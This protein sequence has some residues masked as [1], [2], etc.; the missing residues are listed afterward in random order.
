MWQID[1]QTPY[2][3][4]GTWARDPEGREIWQVVV[5][6]TYGFDPAGTI[7]IAADQPPVNLACVYRGDAESSSLLYESDF[8]PGKQGSDILLNADA[9]APAGGQVPQLLAGFAVA[10]LIKWVQVTG[11]RHWRAGWIRVVA[12][13]PEPFQRM[14]LIWENAYGGQAGINQAT[15]LPIAYA[16]NPVGKGFVT[17]AAQAVGRPLPNIEYPKRSVASC[18]D[19]VLPAGFGAIPSHWMPRKGY[20]GTYDEEWQRTR[21]PL[22]PRDSSS[23]YHRCAPEDQQL[24]GFLQG[25]E[26]VRLVNLTP[27]GKVAFTLPRLGFRFVTRFHGLPDQHHAPRITLL[28]IEP[29][30]SR[31]SLVFQSDLPCQGDEDRLAETLIQEAEATRD[32]PSACG[33]SAC[34]APWE[35]MPSPA[36]WHGVSATASST[37][38]RAGWTNTAS[39]WSWPQYR[40]WIRYCPPTSVYC[41]W[42]CPVPW[43]PW[44]A[45]IGRRCEAPVTA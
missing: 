43:R 20:G 9:W 11:H 40:G 12:S 8:A 13:P 22:P 10:D 6:A 37:N 32:R 28:I 41:S 4:Q 26:P 17:A 1:N 39:P 23:R 15:G 7:R 36:C 35:R 3:A 27:E 34:T 18:T 14:P 16:P 33:A 25:G 31:F 29:N 5:K 38:T 21:F 44:S 30:A 45:W 42:A 19:L 24:P 2:A